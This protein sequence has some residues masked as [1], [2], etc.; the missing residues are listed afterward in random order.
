MGVLKDPL[1]WGPTAATATAMGI[2]RAYE[3]VDKARQAKEK[4]KAYKQMLELN[5]RLRKAQKKQPV[6]RIYNSLHNVNPT[7]AK[8]PLVAGAWV[9]NVIE[10]NAQFGEDSSNQALLTA[11]KDLAGIRA[12]M[13]QAMGRERRDLPGRAIADATIGNTLSRYQALKDEHGQV[14][15]LQN[16]LK[17][18]KGLTEDRIMK[19]RLRNQELMTQKETRHSESMARKDREIEKVRGFAEKLLRKTSSTEG[20]RLLAAIR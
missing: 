17:A 7:L 13:S 11:V 4:S 16:Q 18:V 5:P 8:D 1:F 20:Q 15:A 14:A 3:S 10:S 12:Q 6:A 2:N 9:D 19:E